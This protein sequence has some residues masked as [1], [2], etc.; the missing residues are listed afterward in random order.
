[1]HAALRAALELAPRLSLTLGAV[2]LSLVTCAS[3][4]TAVPAWTAPVLIRLKVTLSSGGGGAGVLGVEV[5]VVGSV[6][7]AFAV[8]VGVGV[9][10]STAKAA[11]AVLLTRTTPVPTLMISGFRTDRASTAHDL[12]NNRL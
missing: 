10:V 12:L 8:A 1:V 9:D 6:D 3:N 11:E 7:G 2:A 5:G 4:L